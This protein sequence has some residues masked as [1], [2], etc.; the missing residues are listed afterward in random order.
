M[1]VSINIFSA[2]HFSL[3]ISDVDKKAPSV[4]IITDLENRQHVDIVEK[5]NAYLKVCILFPLIF[6]KLL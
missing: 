5:I 4:L 1:E 3:Y 2:F 6:S